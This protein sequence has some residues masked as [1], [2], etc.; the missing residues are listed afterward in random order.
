MKH[1]CFF[2]NRSLLITNKK[3]KHM[4]GSE[5]GHEALIK[6]DSQTF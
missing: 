1:F 5:R 4:K 6:C 2:F 3:K